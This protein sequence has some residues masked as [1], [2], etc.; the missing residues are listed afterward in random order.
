MINTATSQF[1]LE[2]KPGSQV[3]GR[4]CYR[5]SVRF[6]TRTLWAYCHKLLLFLLTSILVIFH[7][8]HYFISSLCRFAGR[9]SLNLIIGTALLSLMLAAVAACILYIL[10]GLVSLSSNLS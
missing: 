7:L 10:A 4:R 5:S 2:S 1:Y 3:A 8:L 9:L 6:F